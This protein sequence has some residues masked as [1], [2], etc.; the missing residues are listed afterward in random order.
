MKKFLLFIFFCSAGNAFTQT[1]ELQLIT[2]AA[3]ALGG[4]E[5]ILSVKALTIYGYGQQAYQNGGGNIT[6][7]LDAPQKWVNINGLARTIDLEHGR[8]HLEQRLVQ[9]FVFAYARN[10]NGDTRVNQ[11]LDGDI[12]F[13][14][15]ADGKA[16]RAADANVRTRRI[17][18]LGNPVSLIR[19]ALDPGTKL[20]NLRKE[21]NRQVV[22]LRTV[23]GDKLT[24]AIEID[25]HLPVS[26]SWVGP[27]NNLGDVA[28]RTDFVGY[29]LEKG[30][31]LPSG[32]NT[33]IDFR[34]VV[35]NKLY[36]DKNIVDEVITVMGAP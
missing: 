19:A 36:V 30:L 4:K 32:Y 25:T 29:Q 23:K 6:T 13:N 15:G 22:D 16:V 3:D 17:E 35:W 28:Y 27:D 31:M 7:S 1:P 2:R 14:V 18:M 11:F 8:M 5:R 26:V 9:D 12:A 20:S 24:L 33:T 10:M 21:S 34:N